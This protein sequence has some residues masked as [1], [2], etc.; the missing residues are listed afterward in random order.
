MDIRNYF[1]KEKSEI[2]KAKDSI[3]EK[4][5]KQ[6][7]LYD[8]YFL[9]Q[10]NVVESLVNYIEKDY[11]IAFLKSLADSTETSDDI[12]KLASDLIEKYSED[13]KFEL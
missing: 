3:M 4:L 10:I 13:P 5:T 1:I 2:Q 8:M 11:C 9:G 12:K 6:Q 7:G